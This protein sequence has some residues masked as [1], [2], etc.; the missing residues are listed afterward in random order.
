[1]PAEAV[2]LLTCDAII[3]RIVMAGRS[4]PL[5]VGRRTPVV[6]PALRR[7][8]IARDKGCAFANCGRRAA[9]CDAHH[10]RHWADGG[11]TRLE[12]LVLLCRFHH[13]L[14]HTGR[15]R[16]EMVDSL[17]VVWNHDWGEVKVGARS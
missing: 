8:L 5:D 4:V 12:N 10:I 1:M 17:P 13:R 2:R 6:S 15:F 3:S 7:A 9:W 16:L 11:S 14:V